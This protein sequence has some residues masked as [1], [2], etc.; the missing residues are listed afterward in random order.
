MAFEKDTEFKG[1]QVPHA[2]F[3][4]VGIATDKLANRVQVL[5][6]VHTDSTKEHQ[7]DLRVADFE[8]IADA[9][10]TWAYTKLKTLPEFAGAVDV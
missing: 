10:V 4:V 5:F 2:Y 8:Y 1:L 3:E 6:R 9:T 7:L